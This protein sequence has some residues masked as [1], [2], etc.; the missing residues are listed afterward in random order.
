M[1]GMFFSQITVASL[2]HTCLGYLLIASCVVRLIL[3]SLEVEREAVT[4]LSEVC[5]MPKF[6]M[7]EKTFGNQT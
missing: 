2:L 6:E 3:N 5:A 4:Q 1:H 7:L